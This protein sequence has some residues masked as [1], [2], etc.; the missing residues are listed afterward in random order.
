MIFLLPIFWR[1]LLFSYLKVFFLSVCGFISILL[2]TRLREIAEFATVASDLSSVFLF[3]LYQIPH[4]LPLAFPISALISSILLFQRFSRTSELSALRIAGLSLRKILTPVLFTSFFLSFLSFFTIS[5]ITTTCYIRSKE[6]LYQQSVKNPL[7]LLQ[8][9]NLFTLHNMYIDKAENKDPA[10]SKNLFLIVFSKSYERLQLF[11]ADSLELQ[12]NQLLGKNIS[13]FSYI[14]NI[15]PHTFDTLAIEN[16][17]NMITS[18]NHLSQYLKAQRL[19]VSLSYLPLPLLLSHPK[20]ST[21]TIFLEIL[22]RISFALATLSFTLLGISFGMELGRSSSKKGTLLA[23]GFALFILLSFVLGKATI[24]YY[25]LISL[26]LYLLPQ[27]IALF[28]S[29]KALRNISKGV[30]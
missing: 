14:K 3:T 23:S 1:Y 25:P 10:V 13:V 22:R 12:K 7:M 26:L 18:A 2:V 17:Q 9:E 4:I 30:S 11:H 16:Q 5:E 15:S 29:S 19:S 8:K 27:P 20:Y 6:I 24:K 28:F 21:K